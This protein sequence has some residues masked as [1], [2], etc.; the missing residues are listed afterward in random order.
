MKLPT[1]LVVDA[2]LFGLGVILTQK[3]ETGIAY[4]SRRLTDPEARYSQTEREVLAVVRASKHLNLHLF[5]AEYTVATDR[6]PL[7]GLMN[8]TQSKPTA[9]LQRLCLCLQRYKMK[10]TYRPEWKNQ[11]DYLSR[12]PQKRERIQHHKSWIDQQA[13]QVNITTLKMY[14][15]L[16]VWYKA[17]HEKKPLLTSRCRNFRRQSTHRSGKTKTWQAMWNSEINQLIHQISIAPISPA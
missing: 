13:E 9:R 3:T 1:E 12:H 8:N 7:E 11:A 2:S 5:G 4:A 14:T 16:M 6:K 10:V 17:K 15:H